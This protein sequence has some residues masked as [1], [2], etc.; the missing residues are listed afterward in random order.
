MN[1]KLRVLVVDNAPEILAILSELF[2]GQGFEVVTAVTGTDA[3]AKFESSVDRNAPFNLVSLDINMPDIQG[4]ELAVQLR[5]HGYDGPMVAF[6]GFPTFSMKKKTVHNG[7]AAY[8]NK[9]VLS[10]DLIKAIRDRYC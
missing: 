7:I 3:M 1:K 2:E 10:S 4:P 6:S 8:F 5:S 9:K